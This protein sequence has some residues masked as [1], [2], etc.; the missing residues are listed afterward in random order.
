M[1]RVMLT[2]TDMIF[3]GRR[4]KQERASNSD[5]FFQLK[6]FIGINDLI[7]FTKILK[8]GVFNE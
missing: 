4:D 8:R 5:P 2:V 6:K 1:A 3:C 7:F